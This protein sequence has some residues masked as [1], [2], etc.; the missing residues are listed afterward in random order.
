MTEPIPD[1]AATALAKTAAEHAR[2][3]RQLF[4]LGT[5]GMLAL[6]VYYGL[7]SN[8]EDPIHLYQGL[9]MV[10]LS[11][12][13]S[14]LWARRGR[15]QL[16][17][18]E[19]FLL[20]TAN[21]YALP[22]LNDRTDLRAYAP[23]IVTLCGFMVLLYQV[24][25]IFTYGL[26]RGRPGRSRF[27]TE[28]ILTDNLQ[29]YI[30]YGLILSTIYT[31]FNVF[32]EDLIPPDIN[33]ILRAVF[34]GMALV[35]TFIQSRRWGQGLLTPGERGTLV[36]ML[37]L[38][39]VMQ[40]STLF[41]VGGIS[42]ILLALV[43]Y[44]AGSRRVPVLA[45]ALLLGMV[46]LLHN[47][48]GAMRNKYWD[49]TGVHRQ[50][51]LVNIVPFFA[52]W[53]MDG[54]TVNPSE[55]DAQITKNLIDRSSL[56]QMLCLIATYTPERQP[57]LDGDTYMDIP[58]QFVPRFFW[59]EKPVGHISTYKLAIYYGLQTEQETAKT[60]IGFG[61]IAEAYA[62]FGF[63]G[64]GLLAFAMAAAYKLVTLRTA[65]SPVLSYPGLFLVILMAWSFQ[66][67]WPLSLWLSSMFQATV[68]VLGVPFTLRNFLG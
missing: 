66:T 1:A 9:L 40:F 13:P 56:F 28:E 47:G 64:V 42:A 30:G 10:L 60:T 19:V 59:P 32:Q 45:T 3:S 18:F 50:V 5:L 20:T 62:N 7:T 21:T 17:V 4:N 46:A 54:L 22:L 29:K 24:I 31:Y 57:F 52:E 27:F 12:L 65:N 33:S 39:I 44:V 6:L 51:E 67:E 61:L 34:S 41:L 36:V 25:A 14:L 11:A 55:G 15:A 53:V 63:F 35:I 37:A 48:K 23:E 16:P 58:G 38:Q 8:A 68:T 43:G 49:N 26:I 2:R